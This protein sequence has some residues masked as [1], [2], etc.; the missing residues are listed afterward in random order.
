MP[1]FSPR[2]SLISLI[3]LLSI[4][5]LGLV[6]IGMSLVLGVAFALT[7]GNHYQ[8]KCQWA[9]DLILKSSIVLLGFNL[10]FVEVIQTAQETLLITVITIIFALAT[11]ILLGKFLK[12]DRQLS[13]LIASGTAICGGSAIAAVAPAIYA[14]PAH[15]I[16]SISI[17]FT[18]NAIGLL[19][20]PELGRYLG[21]SQ[22]DFGLWAALGIHD[23]SSVVGAA[24]TFGE[25]SLQVAT[26]TK[27]AR[28]LWIIPLVFVGGFMFHNP[29]KR[30]SFPL[31]ILLFILASLSTMVISF[32]EGVT[33]AIKSLAKTGMAIS[34][35]L[36]GAGFSK[37]T[38]SGIQ[39]TAFLQG[40]LLW[41]LI[42]ASSY[43]LIKIL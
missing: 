5:A 31:F 26:T 13:F 29:S 42:S 23:T 43:G 35:F 39:W 36:I 22:Y 30:F 16:V 18:L 28:A 11:G 24:A 27:L 41:L 10:Q 6:G 32:P 34:L 15:I 33:S 4:V 21:M 1:K 7:I 25:E 17:V 38:L 40:L 19:V 12:V 8:L 9:S 14:R 3:L 20:Y 2:I 37:Q